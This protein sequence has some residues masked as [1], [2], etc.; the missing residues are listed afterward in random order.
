MMSEGSPFF[1]RAFIRELALDRP[2]LLGAILQF[3]AGENRRAVQEAYPGMG[4]PDAIL[5]RLVKDQAGFWDF[6]EE[7][8]RLALVGPEI[9][10]DLVLTW[11]SAFC[12]PILNRFIL[13]SDVEILHRDLGEKYLDFARGRGRFS[14][15][16][17]YRILEVQPDPMAVE[18][19]RDQVLAWGLAAHD[20]VAASWP[21]PLRQIQDRC[22]ARELPQCHGL[23]RPPEAPPLPGMLRA[24]WFS[25]KKILI[26]EVAPQWTPCFS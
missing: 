2:Q 9:T 19:V 10:L 3:N 26:K 18:D 20:L 25:M 24:V 5:D 22:W 7:S 21:V 15:G 13:R 16:D 17:I 8:R 12:A 14:L 6:E 11:G 4:F 23:R 1:P